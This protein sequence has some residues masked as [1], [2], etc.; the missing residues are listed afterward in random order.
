MGI[1]SGRS[2]SYVCFT[3]LGLA[4]LFIAL[5]LLFC[6]N[7]MNEKVWPQLMI[8]WLL[9]LLDVGHMIVTKM[10]HVQ[11]N[12]M[13]GCLLATFHIFINIQALKIVETNK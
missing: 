11:F 4:Q 1:M 6:K 3:I 2:D 8:Y 13:I 7:R 5:V 9:A 10:D 12:V